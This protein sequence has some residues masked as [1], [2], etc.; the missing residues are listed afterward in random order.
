MTNKRKMYMIIDQRD[1]AEYLAKNIDVWLVQRYF[2]SEGN[3]PEKVPPNF[4]DNFI[5]TETEE[6]II[7]E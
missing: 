5:I 1:G 6:E 3:T 4:K 7:H 2:Y